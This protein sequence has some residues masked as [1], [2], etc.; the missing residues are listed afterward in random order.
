MKDAAHDAVF[1]SQLSRMMCMVEMKTE[2]VDR[3]VEK[4]SAREERKRQE[5]LELERTSDKLREAE[6][7][8]KAI[9]DMIKRETAETDRLQKRIEGLTGGIVAAKSR[10]RA[11]E[12]SLHKADA[13]LGE[14]KARVGVPSWD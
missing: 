11:A 3:F 6:A 9:T 4:R 10:R 8:I 12:D 1:T 14:V 7:K 2:E 13:D 5:A